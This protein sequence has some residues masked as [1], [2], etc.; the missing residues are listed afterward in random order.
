MNRMRNGALVRLGR[1]ALLGTLILDTRPAVAGWGDDI[2]PGAGPEL[3]EW[4]A[5]DLAAIVCAEPARREALIDSFIRTKAVDAIE[6]VKR[7][8]DPG[9]RPLF[10]ALLHHPDWHVVHRALTALER[11]D[12]GEALPQALE[13]LTHAEVALREKAAISCLTLW[14]RPGAVVRTDAVAFVEARL[15]GETDVHVRSWEGQP[16]PPRPAGFG[17][18]GRAPAAREAAALPASPSSPSTPR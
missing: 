5:P 15:A 4:V 12:D 8:R 7:F 3:V 9:L 6:A 1:L 17:D 2:E 14:D 16:A 18:D 11:L 13:L 10:R